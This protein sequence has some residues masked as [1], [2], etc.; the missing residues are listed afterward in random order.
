MNKSLLI[1]IIVC[2]LTATLAY[3]ASVSTTTTLYF[4]VA[5]VVAFSNTLPGQSAT[6]AGADTA[7]ANVEFN[8]TTGTTVCA[9]AKVV[10]GTL[11]ESGV[12][13]M[14]LDNTGTVNLNM[15]M[16]LASAMPACMTLYGKT[17]WAADCTSGTTTVTNSKWAIVNDFTPAASATPVYLWTSFNAC[18][19]GDATTRVA[20]VIGNQTG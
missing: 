2:L 17:A 4:N 18:T 15:T 3:A 9:N 20:T 16:A 7:T 13:I 19:A 6:N 1:G 5:T 11:Q 8:S 14:S 12:P 10:A